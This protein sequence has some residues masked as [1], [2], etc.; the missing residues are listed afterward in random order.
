MKTFFHPAFRGRFGVARRD[1]TPPPGIHAKNWGAATHDVATS[2]H[3]PFTLT[4]LTVQD[5]AGGDPFAI[6]ALD[7]G[8]WRSKEESEVLAAAVRSHGIRHHILTPSHTHAGPIFCPGLAEKPGGRHIRPY[9]DRLTTAVGE[10]VAEALEGAQPGLWEV[11]TGHCGLAANRDL[12]DPDTGRLLVGWNPERA[13]DDTVL[14]G[15]LTNEAGGCRA[16]IVNYACHPT[17]LAWE[18]QALSPD[19]IGSMREVIERETGA[20]CVFLQGA[21]GELAPRHQYVGDVA[22]ADR[23]GRELGHAAL[24]VYYGMRTPGTELR[25]EGSLESGATLALWRERRREA[26][27]ENVSVQDVT[28]P[29]EIKPDLPSAETLRQQIADCAGP[30]ERERL[31]RLLFRRLLVGEGNRITQSFALWLLGDLLVVA[32]PAEVYSGL[33]IA[34]RTA[35]APRA[36]FVITLA[37]ETLG[38][39]S[40]EDSFAADSYASAVSPYTRGCFEQVL[41]TLLHQIRQLP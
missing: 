21:S 6:V 10:A 27:P 32:V 3:R 26:V 33:Q 1:I 40:P 13:A 41:A 28:I 9:L 25:F 35:A 31:H 14:V 36:V 29:L 16:T 19:Y 2:L 20:P 11:A 23:A 37:N 8:W 7:L 12:P 5:L 4:V 39:L 17:I 18:N 30:V 22:V 34:L 38:Y 15:R 24:G